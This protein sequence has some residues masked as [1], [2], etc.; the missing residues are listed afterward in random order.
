MN[1]VP[2]LKEQLSNFMDC[3]SPSDLPFKAS[4]D[5]VA[6]ADVSSKNPGSAITLASGTDKCHVCKGVFGKMRSST[7]HNC[8]NC[9]ASVCAAC[10]PSMMKLNDGPLQRVCTPCAATLHEVPAL[11]QQLEHFKREA[12]QGELQEEDWALSNLR[13]RGLLPEASSPG[14]LLPLPSSSL[15]SDSSKG[16]SKVSHGQGSTTL[17]SSSDG[18]LLSSVRSE[19]SDIS[20]SDS[21]SQQSLKQR[22]YVDRQAELAQEYESWQQL[23]SQL[24]KMH[25][26]RLASNLR[27]EEA[28]LQLSETR[29]E[30]RKLQE[31]VGALCSVDFASA[32][33][34]YA[35]VSQPLRARAPF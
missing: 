33:P 7:R 15:R 2:D 14:L 5:S 4:S 26:D 22:D 13:C 20:P 1:Q 3:V 11:Q 18:F 23:Q 21:A 24:E 17:Q 9:L 12:L 28:N 27:V 16:S 10:S 19:N 34:L 6:M 31:A 35:E 29:E 30:L 25:A 8:Q 32:A